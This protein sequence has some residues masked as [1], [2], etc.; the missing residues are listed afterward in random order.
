MKLIS[1]GVWIALRIHSAFSACLYNHLIND[2][3]MFSMVRNYYINLNF[4]AVCFDFAKN[5]L[6]R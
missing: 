5:S 3:S 1:P 2:F 6:F 4:T